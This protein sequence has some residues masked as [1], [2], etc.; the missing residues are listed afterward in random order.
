MKK[1]IEIV[2]VTDNEDGSVSIV[3]DLDLETLK[4]LANIGLLE[5]FKSRAMEV[6]N[7]HSNSTRPADEASGGDGADPL[8]GDFPSF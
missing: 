3:L 1:S 8:S 2:S 6:I 7:G 4:V 5:V